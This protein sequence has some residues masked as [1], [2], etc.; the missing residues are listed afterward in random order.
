MILRVK[1]KYFRSL[2]LFNW[3]FRCGKK[4]VFRK[5]FLVEAPPLLIIQLKRFG[6]SGKKDMTNIDIPL[7][8]NL[9][10]YF[11]KQNASLNYF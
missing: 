1:S 4:E 2:S 8:L 10:K 11:E 5:Y 6:S 3:V 9:E 7:E